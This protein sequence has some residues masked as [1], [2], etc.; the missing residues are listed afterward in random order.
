MLK[1]LTGLENCTAATM[2]LR[3][4]GVGCPVCEAARRRAGAVH[5]PRCTRADATDSDTSTVPPTPTS[6]RPRS[7]E[8]CPSHA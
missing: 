4:I 8:P 1:L 3:G 6:A 5:G 2:R 7:P